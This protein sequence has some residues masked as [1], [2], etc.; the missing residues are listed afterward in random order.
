VIGGSF[1]DP[2]EMLFAE[3]LGGLLSEKGY[4]VVCGGGTG[5][6]EAVCHG[7]ALK[8]GHSIGILRGTDPSEANRWVETVLLTGM[9]TSRNRIIALS[10]KVVIAVGG[11]YGTLSEIAYALQA[12][13]PVCAFGKWSCLDGVV[14]VGSP[15]EAMDFVIENAGGEVC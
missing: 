14:H 6:M 9:G 7:I 4:T 8:G 13:K 15:G 3:E 2:E 12:G 1:A 5:V 11:K 10:G